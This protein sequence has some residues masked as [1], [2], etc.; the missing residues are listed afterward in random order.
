M[1]PNKHEPESEPIIGDGTARFTM[2][3]FLTL[4]TIGA[5][6]LIW[7]GLS[8]VLEGDHWI[9]QVMGALRTFSTFSAMLLILY[10]VFAARVFSERREGQLRLR[11]QQGLAE[12]RQQAAQR[13]G[14]EATDVWKAWTEWKELAEAARMD[15]RPEP[16][17]PPGPEAPGVDA[18][19]SLRTLSSMTAQ[20]HLPGRG[21]RKSPSC[22]T[23]DRPSL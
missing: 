14:Q 6:L 4:F 7:R 5:A 23:P 21:R 2:V 15:G 17:P 1:K 11:F 20:G 16:E 19:S 9:D 22:G 8:T 12:G 3:L 10:L 18:A 13:F